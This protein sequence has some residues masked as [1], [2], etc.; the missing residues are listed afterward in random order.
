M[1]LVQQ[2][3]FSGVLFWLLEIRFE[4]YKKRNSGQ[5]DFSQSQGAVDRQ[6]SNFLILKSDE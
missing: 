4:K 2:A 6:L 1:A 5:S 3:N